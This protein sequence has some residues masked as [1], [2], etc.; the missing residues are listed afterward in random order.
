[1]TELTCALGPDNAGDVL[2]RLLREARM[3]ID[4]AVYEI[5]PSYR[6]ML[7]SAVHR[8][9]RV[10]LLLDNHASDGNALTALRVRDSG[11]ECRVPER[12]QAHAKLLVIDE[13][14]LA[15]GTG[16]LIWRDAPRHAADHAGMLAGT[17][18]WWAVVTRSPSLSRQA[19]ARFEEIWAQAA[20]PPARW[21]GAAPQ[22]APPV[23]V[24]RPQL[25]P[26]IG[27]AKGM[28]AD[29]TAVVMSANWSATGMG[30]SFEAALAISEPAAVG[31]FADAW[32]RDWAAATPV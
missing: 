11:G 18:E 14:H 23:G 7:A 28:A 27:Q 2:S 8:G 21:E 6:W 9:V 30:Q 26:P 1:M 19:R 15:V 5:G 29:G 25:P 20:P 10:R 17:R 32:A 16:N 31:Y 13:R 3:S 22:V 12:L 4:A 24:P